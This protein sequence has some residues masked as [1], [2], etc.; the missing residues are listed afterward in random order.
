MQAR[1]SLVSLLSSN[2]FTLLLAAC[3]AS[4]AT[5]LFQQDNCTS[6]TPSP[7]DQVFAVAFSPDIGI[8]LTINTVR[9]GP[10]GSRFLGSQTA[11]AKGSPAYVTGIP[12]SGTSPTGTLVFDIDGN[13]FGASITDLAL[14]DGAVAPILAVERSQ[15]KLWGVENASFLLSMSKALGYFFGESDTV[16]PVCRDLWERALTGE[17]IPSLQ[18]GRE[19]EIGDG[20]VL[21]RF[22]RR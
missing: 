6:S 3:T 12:L 20:V 15:Q 10:S 21:G 19:W 9:G 2:L 7:K 4:N 5:P 1:C 18:C 16:C 17:L 11:F 13:P 8:W 14:N 22:A